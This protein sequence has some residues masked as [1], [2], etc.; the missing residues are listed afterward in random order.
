MHTYTTAMAAASGTVIS[1]KVMGEVEAE[2]ASASRE[3][4]ADEEARGPPGLA[5]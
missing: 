5:P 1:E 2:A 3:F 4:L